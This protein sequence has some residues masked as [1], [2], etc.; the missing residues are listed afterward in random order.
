MEIY[1]QKGDASF[2]LELIR[3]GDWDNVEYPPNDSRPSP[4]RNWWGAFRNWLGI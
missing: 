2:I 3:L 1:R 4:A